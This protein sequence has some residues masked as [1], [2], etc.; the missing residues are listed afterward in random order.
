[1]STVATSI[2]H[3][4]GGSSQD[5]EKERGGERMGIRGGERRKVG[6]E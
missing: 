4:T 2:Q 5:N 1:M 6:G 3:Y